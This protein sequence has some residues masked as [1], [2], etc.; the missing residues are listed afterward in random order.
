MAKKDSYKEL[1][2]KLAECEKIFNFSLDMIG[3]GN[4]SGY[5]TRI[6]SSFGRILGY[7]DKEFLASPF[8]KFVHRQDIKKTQKALTAAASGQREIFIENRYKCKDGSYRWIDWRVL[9][10]TEEDK[11]Y[12]V[13][14]DITRQKKTEKKLERQKRELLES[15]AKY[16]ALVET[17]SDW[18]W[19]VDAK[20][21]Y[22]YASPRVKELLG[23]EP[24]EVLNRTPFDFMS[25]KE[26]KRTKKIFESF[27]AQQ[28]PIIALEN[29]NLHKTG[30]PVVLETSGMP[31]FDA[32]GKFCG[33][34]GIDR[35]ITERKSAI[36][37]LQRESQ[38]LEETNIAL[39]IVLRE[40]ETTKA[41]LDKN[42]LTNVKNLLEPY[43]N[44]LDAK[45]TSAEQRFFLNII[46]ANIDTITSS[47]SK[48]LKFEM[49]NL[50]PKEV[51]VADLI[52][53]GRSNK[54]IARLLG[55]TINTVDF[56]RRNLR[57]KLNI[58]GK[59]SNL[60]TYLQKYVV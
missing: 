49:G 2:K 31:I 56:H 13:G 25:T 53:Q 4:L 18:V 24:E 35:D 10:S 36:E 39:R 1:E 48:N 32:E 26:A 28:K 6:N 37:K 42:I 60:R 22:T 9:V 51:Q 14:R 43:V 21:R 12:A 3:V 40:S 19:E 7:T 52:R 27:V 33:Y 58:K 15:K 45:L 46:K 34:R 47:F 41:E 17:T 38:K 8:L 16:Q 11:F 23:Y 5:F 29:I 57:E 44:E 20:G 54:E 55:I 30:H 59:K 50:T